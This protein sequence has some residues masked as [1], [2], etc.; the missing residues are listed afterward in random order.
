MSLEGK[1]VFVTGASMPKGIGRTI[2]LTL[3]RQGADVAVSGFHHMEGAQAVADEVRARV[4]KPLPS[5][6]MCA[7]TRMF[8]R[9]LLT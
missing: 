9:L 5:K 4:E 8:R 7:A 2:A 6:W 1:V 3:A